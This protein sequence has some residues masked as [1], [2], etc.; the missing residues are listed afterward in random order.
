[1][2]KNTSRDV[3]VQRPAIFPDDAD[4]WRELLAHAEVR[5]QGY[6]A[7][8]S[9]SRILRD[10][11]IDTIDENQWL[12]GVFACYALPIFETRAEAEEWGRFRASRFSMRV[13]R[14]VVVRRVIRGAVAP[15]VV[16]Q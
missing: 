1:M 12:T 13:R 10:G 14:S 16:G 6:A 3:Q 7:T 11:S 5:R 15:L 9:V 4:R 2:H 8:E